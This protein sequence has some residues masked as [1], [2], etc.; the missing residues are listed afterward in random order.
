V[1]TF[2]LLAGAKG[3]GK[4]WVADI[5]QQEFGVHYVDAD[6]L[7]LDLIERGVEPDPLF[8]WLEPV[9]AA[10]LDALRSRP[11]VS[12]EITGAWDSDY[13]LAGEV[14]Q[15]GHQVVRVLISAPLE[16]TLE[17]LRMRRTRKVP[18]SEDEARSEYARVQ[19][20]VARERWDARLDTS[21]V[22]DRERATRVLRQLLSR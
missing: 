22:E 9:R 15:G 10:V 4:S 14:E 20:R 6:L 17:R 8:G 1:A 3:V 13:K 21:G 19:E 5:A 7:I 2:L 11:F 12:A 16:E 18:V